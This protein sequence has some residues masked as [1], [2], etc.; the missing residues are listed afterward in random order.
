MKYSKTKYD[1]KHTCRQIHSYTY[2]YIHKHIHIHIR[3]NIHIHIQSAGFSYPRA[4]H[5]KDVHICSNMGSSNI[6]TPTPALMNSRTCV[7]ACLVTLHIK[8]SL[9]ILCTFPE[10]V[11]LTST[12][13]IK[14]GDFGLAKLLPR[15]VYVSLCICLSL[16]KKVIFSV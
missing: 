2:T 5:N 6:Y 4:C 9:V 12:N 13:S 14:I 15:Y 11:F 8:F 3:I 16:K 10:N 7:R 1:N